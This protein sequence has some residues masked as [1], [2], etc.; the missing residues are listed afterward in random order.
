MPVI[1][2]SSPAARLPVQSFSSERSSLI[3]YPNLEPNLAISYNLGDFVPNLGQI[4]FRC[5]GF[6]HGLMKRL[7]QCLGL[8]ALELPLALQPMHKS[9]LIEDGGHC[10]L[11]RR[12]G[13]ARFR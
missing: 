7:A 3:W 8:A 5:D 13:N 9:K 4:R 11:L 6:A 12:P 10:H 1:A 2:A